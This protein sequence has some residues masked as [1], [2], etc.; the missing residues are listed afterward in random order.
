[1]DKYLIPL[2]VEVYNAK[3]PQKVVARLC[4]RISEVLQDMDDPAESENGENVIV[5]IGWDAYA[6]IPLNEEA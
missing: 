2:K 4:D 3:Y 6:R 1:M 5:C